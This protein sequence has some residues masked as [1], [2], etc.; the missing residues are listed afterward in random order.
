[1][2]N[3]IRSTTEQLIARARGPAGERAPKDVFDGLPSYL[4]VFGNFFSSCEAKLHWGTATC[5]TVWLVRF[6]NAPASVAFV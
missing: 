3:T 1:M 2:N 6:L 4:R 5:L